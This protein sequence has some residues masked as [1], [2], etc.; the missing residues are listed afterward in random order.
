MTSLHETKQN[1][2][3]LSQQIQPSNSAL[4]GKRILVPRPELQSSELSN[5]LRA[6]GAIPFHVPLIAIHQLKQ[7]AELSAA[8]DQLLPNDW[9]FITS[10]NAIPAVDRIRS[11]NPEL[12]QEGAVFI[13]AV[14]PASAKNAR[15][16]GLQVDF[17]PSVHNGASLAN[18]LGERLRGRRVLLPRSDKALP[19]LPELI[20]KY[21]G[22]PLEVVAYRTE[23]CDRDDTLAQLTAARADAIALFS[24]SEMEALAHLLTNSGI[25]SVEKQIPIVA[26]G[27]ETARSCRA[28]GVQRPIVAADTTIDAVLHALSECFAAHNED[29]PGANK[30]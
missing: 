14:G 30:R 17:V 10:Q 4:T 2:P 16:A 11:R 7:F 12:L 5:A 20:R 15:A 23:L 6:S 28:H 27:E 29:L 19:D 3:A 26:I 22:E 8:A 24:P 21:G 9:I 25:T 13:A 1:A 18:E